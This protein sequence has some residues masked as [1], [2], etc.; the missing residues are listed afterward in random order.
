MKISL[1]LAACL[2]FASWY[3]TVSEIA[4]C[5]A[6]TVQ[7]SD[8][9]LLGKLAK[10]TYTFPDGKIKVKVPPLLEPGA[11]VRDEKV[12]VLTQVIFTDDLG[13]FYRVVVVNNVPPVT[14]L[15]RIQGV[16]KNPQSKKEI[17]T[18]RGREVHLIDL[19]P[20]GA[21]IRVTSF[22]K[23]HNNQ[24]VSST[25]TPDLLTAN[26]LFETDHAIIHVIAGIPLFQDAAVENKTDL[27]K[28]KLKRFLEGVEVLPAPGQ[29]SGL[30]RR[31]QPQNTTAF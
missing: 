26:V 25:M 1:A 14:T 15:D 4:S 31:V 13:T 5:S 18:A 27:V 21:E 3:P 11:K 22:I 24:F 12:E 29:A 19:E 10:G 30:D 17:M 7:R 2:L 28:E 20:E 9:K 23:D 16:F 8:K 6:K